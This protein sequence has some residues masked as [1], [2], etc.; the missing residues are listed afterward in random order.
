MNEIPQILE[1]TEKVMY[2][3]NPEYIPFIIPKF[4]GSIFVTA[5]L[6]FIGGPYLT[7]YFGSFFFSLAAGII[8]LVIGIITSHLSYTTTYYTITNKRAIIQSGIIGRDFKS[9]EFDKMQNI[10]VNVGLLG[11]IFKVG[12]IRIF[13]GEMESTGRKDDSGMRAKYDLFKSITS[14][15]EV[16]K[17]LQTH[18]SKR[19]EKLR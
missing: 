3:G 17:K 9:I 4:I 7:A 12:D 14:P 1:K 18:L 11:V 5:L 15:Q 13:T 6:M 10:S 19:K 2:A 8:I 16:L